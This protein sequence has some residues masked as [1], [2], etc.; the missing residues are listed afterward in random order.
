MVSAVLAL[1]VPEASMTE[2]NALL[3][4]QAINVTIQAW[5]SSCVQQD[6]IHSRGTILPAHPVP[7]APIALPFMILHSLA[8][9]GHILDIERRIALHALQV[10]SA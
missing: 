6:L 3:V 8:R 1:W 4:L 10:T 5:A 2:A 7:R 9:L